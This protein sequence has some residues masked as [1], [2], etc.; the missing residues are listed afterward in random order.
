MN[1]KSIVCRRRTS[2]R[3]FLLILLL[4]VTS[5]AAAQVEPAR[6]AEPVE[7][8]VATSAPVVLDGRVLF[9]LQGIPS[10]PAEE[11]A[12]IISARIQDLA[13]DKTFSPGTLTLEPG[14]EYTSIMSGNKLVVGVHDLDAFAQGVGRPVLAELV[15]EKIDAAV[16]AYR[17]ERDFR[18]LLIHSGYAVG[19][20]F[21]LAGLIF[22][23]WRLSRR[24]NAWIERRY[25]SRIQD[26][27][28]KSFQVVQ[29]ERLWGAVKGL[30]HGVRTL[31]TIL[32]VAVGAE[33]ILGLF[34][35][36]RPLADHGLNLVLTPLR[37]MAAGMIGA[38][39]GL[40]FIAILWFVIRYL[41]KLLRLFFAGI[42]NQ[43][44]SLSG[45]DPEWSWTT[46]KIL[47]LGIVAFGVVIAYPY[48]PGADTAA[49]KGVSLF[50]GVVFSLSSTSA[51]SNIIAGYTLT[52][53]RA[54]KLGDRVRIGEMTGDVIQ[55]RHQVT[56][57]C[58][59]K[60]E[61]VII[62]NSS[63]LN[64]DVINYSS[65]ARQRGL[66]LHTTVG[67][68]YETPWRQVEALLMLAAGRTPGLLE[69]PPPFILQKALGDFCVTYELNV[70]TDR[71]LD[72]ARLYA[73]LHRNILD[74][75]NEYEIQI[76]TPAYER[77]PEQPKVVPKDKWFEAPASLSAGAEGHLAAA[78]PTDP[79]SIVRSNLSKHLE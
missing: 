76:M 65:L 9:P 34:P 21:L 46:Y 59:L 48:I 30:V 27:Q 13:T 28:V 16:R 19:A 69:D 20:V 8:S 11:R 29:A 23:V 72:S 74:V 7:E 57:L 2:L 67:I 44:I 36:T 70:Y 62:P 25:R 24:Q 60:N 52:Y 32:L 79:D 45:F 68:G 40:I 10:Y 5:L 73:E 47:R 61:E 1:N 77:D 14:D 55:I 4:R 56:H 41:L 63:I 18:R 42:E 37:S 53:R 78:A 51:L 15:K 17:E 6:Q 22:L 64:T 3:Y 38:V 58:S 71:P 12:R 66:I 31:I 39:P 54:F 50:L 26:V 43:T 49:F 35:W 33:Y 75:F